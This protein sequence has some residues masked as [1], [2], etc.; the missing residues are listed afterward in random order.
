MSISDDPD[1]NGLGYSAHQVMAS[2]RSSGLGL[3]SLSGA[4]ESR[5]SSTLVPFLALDVV[6][7]KQGGQRHGGNERTVCGDVRMNPQHHTF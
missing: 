4:F 6:L 5:Q 1:A 7:R 3:G 2:M